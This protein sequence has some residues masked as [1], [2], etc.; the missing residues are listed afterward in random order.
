[1]KYLF[2]FIGIWFATDMHPSAGSLLAVDC[3]CLFRVVEQFPALAVQLMGVLLGKPRDTFA[4][5][6]WGLCKLLACDR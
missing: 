3:T 5:S 1:M 6:P 4:V 2:M